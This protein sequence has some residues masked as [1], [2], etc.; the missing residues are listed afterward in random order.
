MTNAGT[1]SA[2]AEQRG[3]EDSGE[4]DNEEGNSDCI[5]YSVTLQYVDTLLDYMGQQRF[6]YS[7]ITAMM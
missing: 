5:S 3:E 6:E 4:D 7:N 1:I 2:T